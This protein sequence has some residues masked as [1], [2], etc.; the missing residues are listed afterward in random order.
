MKNATNFAMKNAPRFVDD[1]HVLVTKAFMKNARIFGTPEY[2]MWKEIRLDCPD[3][4]MVP[5]TIKKNPN[6]RVNTKNMTYPRM[7]LFISLQ[8]NSETL[9]KEF[10]KQQQLSKVQTDPYRY[11]LAWFLQTFE[12]YDE[13]YKAFFEALAKKDENKQNAS[14]AADA[15]AEKDSE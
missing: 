15:D 7:K 13:D 10:E 6:K 8:D 4:V 3:A 5:K 1:P 14:C 2:K 12:D 9:L 11:V